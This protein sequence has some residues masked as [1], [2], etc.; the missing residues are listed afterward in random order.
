MRKV[1]GS[2]GIESGTMKILHFAIVV[3]LQF[4]NFELAVPI[5]V[6]LVDPGMLRFPT[7]ER[8]P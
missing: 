5:S 6:Q 3:W 7:V 1:V 2:L 4:S 8:R